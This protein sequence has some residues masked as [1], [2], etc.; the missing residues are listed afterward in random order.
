MCSEAGAAYP[1]PLQVH[2]LGRV[3][4]L[5]TLERMQRYTAER[6]H[7][8]P[9]QLWLCEHPPVYTQG[10]AGRAQHLLAPA[11]IPVVQSNRGGQVTYHGPGQI[12]AYLLLDLNRRGYFVK[13]YVRRLEQAVLDTLAEL[14]L[15]G[16]R[17]EG[18]PGIYVEL[19]AARMQAPS[20]TLFSGLGKIAA[21]GI[22]VSRGCSYH[23]LALNVAMDLEP[24]SRINPC[25]Y[26]GLRTVDLF[27][28]GIRVD[29]RQVAAIL[30]QQLIRHL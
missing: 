2:S 7:D 5:N 4:Y 25:G 11:G 24:Y 16:Q 18:A 21:L 14:G 13:D 20:N 26:A 12:V 17:V 3:D 10:Q 30:T 29:A 28:M 1:P 15:P 27:T 22:K 6:T 9:D 8:S 23:G 19:A